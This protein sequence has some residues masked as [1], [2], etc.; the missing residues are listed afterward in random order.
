MKTFPVV[1]QISSKP[2]QVIQIHLK[3][4]MAW[5]D[6][7]GILLPHSN[8]WF[9]RSLSHE[10]VQKSGTPQNQELQGR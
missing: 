3:T 7:K 5:A 10:L 9:F 1:R 6:E 8:D 2:K 4:R